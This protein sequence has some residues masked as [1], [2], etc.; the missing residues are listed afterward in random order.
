MAKPAAAHRISTSGLITSA[1]PVAPARP[2]VS[3]V[4][5]R[6][7]AGVLVWRC[8]VNQRNT[9]NAISANPRTT[10]NQDAQ[11]GR[12]WCRPPSRSDAP[13]NAAV[14]ATRPSTQPP[15]KPSF[16]PRAAII[17]L[18]RPASTMNWAPLALAPERPRRHPVRDRSLLG[19]VRDRVRHQPPPVALLA[20]APAAQPSLD[21]LV[22]LQAVGLIP[23]RAVRFAWEEHRQV[24]QDRDRRAHQPERAADRLAVVSDRREVAHLSIIRSIPPGSYTTVDRLEGRRLPVTDGVAR[25]EMARLAILSARFACFAILSAFGGDAVGAVLGAGAP[26]FGHHGGALGAV[27]QR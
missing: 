17:P 26:A 2:G 22:Q 21:D 10:R 23:P 11:V 4:N 20:D 8:R 13:T 9:P 25:T 7:Q 5:E 6:S 3:L 12:A 14:R 18:T 24:D 1:A 16:L 19:A 15:K 27:V